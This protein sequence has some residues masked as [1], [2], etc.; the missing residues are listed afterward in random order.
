MQVTKKTTAKTSVKSKEMIDSERNKKLETLYKRFPAD[1][2]AG[3]LYTTPHELARSGLTRYSDQ[4]IRNFFRS[5][6][7]PGAIQLGRQIILTQQAVEF[8]IERD[9]KRLTGE[10]YP[11]KQQPGKKHQRKGRLRLTNPSRS[12]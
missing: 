12:P 4:Q 9:E 2:K 10:L 8:V 3:D 5:G 6:E 11:D 1:I 7:M